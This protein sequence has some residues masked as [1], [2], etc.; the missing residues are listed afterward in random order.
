M[1]IDQLRLSADSTA[2][3]DLYFMDFYFYS[4]ESIADAR[5]SLSRE[6]SVL[7]H[8]YSPDTS[9]LLSLTQISGKKG[10][11]WSNAGRNGL[12]TLY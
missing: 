1:I 4:T 12:K 6:T 5:V 10:L 2:I 11:G 7:S 8:V 9:N 3:T